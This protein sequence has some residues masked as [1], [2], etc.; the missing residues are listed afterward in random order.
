MN[1]KFDNE[2]EKDISTPN[3]LFKV[4]KGGRREPMNVGNKHG[5]SFL[6]L[7]YILG[8]SGCYVHKTK[9]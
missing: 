3:V 6:L 4:G 2:V 9:W 7:K 1:I 5:S 8:L